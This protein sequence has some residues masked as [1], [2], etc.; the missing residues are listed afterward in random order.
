M[1]KLL[2]AAVL[3]LAIIFIVTRL[4]DLEQIAETF[5]R[6]V[7]LWLLLA[8]LVHLASVLNNGATLRSLYRLLGLKEG[9]GRLM[10]LWCSSVFFTTVTSSGGWGGMAVFVTDGRKRGLP[11][12]RVTVASAMYYLYDFVS[13]LLV[14][15]LGLIVLV[16][17]GQ[18]D[19]GEIL[20]SVVLAVY[21]LFLAAWLILAWRSPERLAAV[22]TK[23]GSFIN[24]LVRPFV[25]R[26]DYLDLQRAR[27]LAHDM[28]AGLTEVRRSPEGLL[29][30]IALSLSHKALTIAILFLCFLAFSQ[31]FSVGTLIAGYS[32]GYIFTVVT[33][34][35]AGIGFVEGILTLAFSGFG[36]PVATSAVIA[37]AYRGI[38]LWLSLLYG[39][40]SFRWV[41]LGPK[42]EALTV[43]RTRPL[44]PPPDLR[45]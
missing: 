39:M 20:A 44:R 38:T 35:P 14:V 7:P 45:P 32:L 34:T 5:R 27:S 40:L 30:P 18:L 24:R 21:A 26:R 13:A 29:L 25:R 12:A 43:D 2:L 10:M 3:L 33:P 16:R 11:A 31:P 1:R 28:G 8:V 41:G 22:M 42:P 37:L 15:G 17:R 36:I 19:T 4:S 9:V 23:G 6:G